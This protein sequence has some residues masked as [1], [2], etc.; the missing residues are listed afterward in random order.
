[1]TTA[2]AKKPGK[3][4][5]NATNKQKFEEAKARIA[6]MA[7]D[8]AK[9]FPKAKT[10]GILPLSEQLTPEEEDARDGKNPAKKPGKGKGKKKQGEAAKP[11]WERS[12]VGIIETILQR[13][14][15]ASKDKPVTKQEILDVLRKKFP[16]R[17][18]SAM[19]S[20][21]NHQVP[22]YLNNAGHN[23]HKSADGKG[24]WGT[25]KKAEQ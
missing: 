9:H 8:N 19:L 13:L 6:R 14:C 25:R 7:A 24:Y 21:I 15:K 22:G 16:D 23:I 2:T 18:A 4:K 12:R 1:M 3:G 11:E 10:P 20:T 5:K 17:K